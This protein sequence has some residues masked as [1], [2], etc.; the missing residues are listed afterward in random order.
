MTVKSFQCLVRNE[1]VTNLPASS[2]DAIITT[3]INAPANRLPRPEIEKK[4]ATPAIVID[5]N[6]TKYLN[7]FYSGISGETI[8][9]GLP[10]NCLLYSS[11]FSCTLN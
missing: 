1:A 3:A 10:V 8:I 5:D 6:S 7:T 4:A 9:R 11:N 2:A